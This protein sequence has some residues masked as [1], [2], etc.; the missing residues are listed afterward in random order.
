MMKT[1]Y[2]VKN[3]WIILYQ[4]SLLS[5]I[6]CKKKAIIIFLIIFLFFKYFILRSLNN[7]CVITEFSFLILVRI[8][9]MFNTNVVYIFITLRY[10]YD[11]VYCV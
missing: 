4:K 8:T 7:Y 10:V 6:N 9:K 1:K 3:V 11:I 2:Y 5:I